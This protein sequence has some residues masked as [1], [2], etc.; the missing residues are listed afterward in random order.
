MRERYS[1]HHY[2]GTHTET[3]TTA[4]NAAADERTIEKRK[5]V[6]CY[7]EVIC[8]L[9]LSAFFRCVDCLRLVQELLDEPCSNSDNNSR[10]GING[11]FF[12]VSF[13]NT[14]ATSSNGYF[15][16]CSMLSKYTF[17]FHR[18]IFLSLCLLSLP[19]EVAFGCKINQVIKQHSH[20]TSALYENTTQKKRKKTH[21]RNMAK[22][23]KTS[24]VQRI[25]VEF[26][27]CRFKKNEHQKNGN[28]TGYSQNMD[29]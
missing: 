3:T 25:C 8:C 2:I 10:N 1:H 14:H 9:V 18:S 4:K 26:M 27:V 24:S 19:L 5:L 6:S 28:M 12:I 20:T 15:Q 17:F 16:L 11:V 21:T 29:V 7:V 23:E 13:G 22:K